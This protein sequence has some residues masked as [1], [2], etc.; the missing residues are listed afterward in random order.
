MMKRM[1]AYRR[2]QARPADSILIICGAIFYF[3][4]LFPLSFLCI[5]GVLS[6][7][8]WTSTSLG[9]G[10]ITEYC[11]R[12]GDTVELRHKIKAFFDG[13][14][15]VP[16]IWLDTEYFA[17]MCNGRVVFG[18]VSSILWVYASE[19]VHST[20]YFEP[21][22][23]LMDARYTLVVCCQNQQYR[24]RSRSK[25]D[26]EYVQNV[27]KEQNSHIMIGY[28]EENQQKYKQMHDRMEKIQ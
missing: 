3:I 28:S 12:Q 17:G 27:W 25:S 9:E 10:M 2:R 4:D 16:G 5:F 26:C 20:I 8:V 14:E 7:I 24:L 21:I 6:N 19:K 1:R 13:A 15:V 11:R 18:N 22:S 23:R